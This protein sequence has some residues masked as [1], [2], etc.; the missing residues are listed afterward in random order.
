M[1]GITV[2]TAALLTDADGSIAVT[3]DQGLEHAVT[4]T[5]SARGMS[6]V[7]GVTEGLPVRVPAQGQ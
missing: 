4:V 2:P 5:A 7:D 1:T 3:D 6:V